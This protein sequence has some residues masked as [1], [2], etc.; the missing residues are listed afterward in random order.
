[1]THQQ[2]QPYSTPDEVV[3]RIPLSALR[4]ICARD[5]HLNSHQVTYFSFSFFLCVRSLCWAT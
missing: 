5:P 1:M 2:K 3:G 4:D